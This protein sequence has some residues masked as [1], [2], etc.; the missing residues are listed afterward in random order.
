MTVADELNC[1]R[2]YRYLTPTNPRL[3]LPSHLAAVTVPPLTA[4]SITVAPT[5]QLD[6]P[7]HR[8]GRP[9]YG[10]GLERNVADLRGRPAHKAEQPPCLYRWESQC[11][12]RHCRPA[13]R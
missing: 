2:L 5:S 6:R 4:L 10:G 7:A 1:W 13:V 8:K 11:W 12:Q 3:K 9:G